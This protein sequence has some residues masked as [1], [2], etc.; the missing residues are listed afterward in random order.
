MSVYR[1]KGS[2]FW[3][4]SFQ[5]QNVRFRGSTGTMNRQQAKTIE[6][7]KREKVEIA[8]S[9]QSSPSTQIEG[10]QQ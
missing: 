9:R 6:R 10:P 3:H 5:Y 2:P 1:V 7:A 4:Y 8:N